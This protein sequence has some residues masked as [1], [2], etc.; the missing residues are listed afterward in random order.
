[1][2]DNLSPFLEPSM[3]I[4]S[5]EGYALDHGSS[6]SGLPTRL[7]ASNSPPIG[8]IAYGD[9]GAYLYTA[10]DYS[11]AI[12]SS[13]TADIYVSV[14]DEPIEFVISG[15]RRWLKAIAFQPLVPRVVM[16]HGFG[17]VCVMLSPSHSFYRHFSAAPLRKVTVLDRKAFAPLNGAIRNVSLGDVECD[18]SDWVLSQIVSTAAREFAIP[19][20]LDPRIE[21]TK[22]ILDEDPSVSLKDI[23]EV[24]ELS[25]YR[26][27]HMF[28]KSMGMSMRSY[29]VWLKLDR[30]WRLIERNYNLA[31]V[32]DEAGFSDS[33][34]LCHAFQNAY[35]VPIAR[36]LRNLSNRIKFGTELDSPVR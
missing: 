26:L 9:S 22:K 6:L 28:S 4:G 15:E 5:N 29:R 27:S 24:V 10:R 31:D 32:A 20:L 13:R 18:D 19:K 14:N 35:G 23:A 33:T 12:K 34:H 3:E 8:E 16:D 1:M 36:H 21:A 25:S 2:T 30:A 7:A 17:L 11:R